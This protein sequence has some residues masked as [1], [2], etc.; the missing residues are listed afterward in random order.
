VYL[1]GRLITKLLGV[2]FELS[3]AEEQLQNKLVYKILKQINYYLK[4]GVQIVSESGQPTFQNSKKTRCILNNLLED[5]YR[6]LFK[7]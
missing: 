1:L 2:R 6:L 5:E 4:I 3:L 7:K